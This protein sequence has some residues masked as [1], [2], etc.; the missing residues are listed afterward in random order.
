MN[1]AIGLLRRAGLATLAW[2]ALALCGCSP[3]SGRDAVT[4]SLRTTNEAPP[5][6]LI[7]QTGSP[8]DLGALRGQVVLLTAVYASC[9]HECPLIL[10]T[11]KRVVEELGARG[12]DLRVVAVTIDPAHDTPEV[13][14]RLGE[15]H[16]M[17][18]PRWRFVT[19]DTATVART[20]DRMNIARHRDPKTG[21]IDH[22]D[23]FLLIDRQG[24]LAF[25]FTSSPKQE[26]QLVEALRI[27]LR[28]APPA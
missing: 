20:L 18:P 25:Q 5:L 1:R 4:A 3:A 2:A 16:G 19:G 12:A 10:S 22:A 26:R 13:L 6:R 23:L 24:K 15:L 9:P 11:A 28:E 27:L 21:I 7:D 14:A 17:Q 8:V